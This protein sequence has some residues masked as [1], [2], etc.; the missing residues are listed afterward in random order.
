MEKLNRAM[1]PTR[2]ADYDFTARRRRAGRSLPGRLGTLSESLSRSL[3]AGLAARVAACSRPTSPRAGAL[4]PV[5][6]GAEEAVDAL[7]TSGK[8]LRVTRRRRAMPSSRRLPRASRRTRN[9]RARGL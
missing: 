7:G 6:W 8:R 4:A 2:G 1:S 9:P 3:Q 5:L